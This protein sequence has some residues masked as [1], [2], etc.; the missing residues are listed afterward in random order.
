MERGIRRPNQRTNPPGRRKRRLVSRTLHAGCRPFARGS[1]NVRSPLDKG[2]IY[3]GEY[4]VNWCPDC[5][6]AISDLE[7]IH[8]ETEGHLWHVRYQVI[9]ERRIRYVSRPLAPKPCSATPRLPFIPKTIAIMHFIGK[10]VT[11]PLL[12]REIPLIADTMVDPEFGTG[13]VKI[14]PAHDP[15]D[16]EAGS[17]TIWLSSK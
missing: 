6:T 2:L 14:T 11:L 13:V 8:E 16:F 12:D 15:N 3:R 9:G 5:Q 17:A 1:R 4:M 10:T 7:T